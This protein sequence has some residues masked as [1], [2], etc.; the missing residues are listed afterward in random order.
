MGEPMTAEG[1]VT[2][3]IG[4]V[5]QGDEAAAQKLWE[6]YFQRLVRMARKK[7][8][9]TP[10]RVADE[11]D[12]ALGALDS[13][14][15]RAEEGRFPQLK[16]RNDLWRLL[17][18]ITTRKALNLAQHEHRKKR[19]SGAV[20]G[21]SALVGPEGEARSNHIVGK[22]PSPEFATLMAEEYQRLLDCLGDGELRSVAQ[23]K[24]EG[25]SNDEIAEKLGCVPRS[26][27]RKLRLIATLWEDF[28]GEG[29]ARDRR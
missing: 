8:H 13:F 24:L 3:W 5:K 10:K 18:V 26:V 14:F 7:L 1:S 19:G 4:Q 6:L 29:S 17:V 11:E 9:G 12:V 23:W 28:C 21:E 27:Q 16:D 2:R 20:R 25:L 22:E 15:R